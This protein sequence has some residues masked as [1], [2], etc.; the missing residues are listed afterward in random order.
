VIELQLDYLPE[1]MA[2]LLHSYVLNSPAEWWV[3][4]HMVNGTTSFHSTGTI[5]ERDQDW[6]TELTKSLRK[7][8]MTFSFTRSIVHQ[9]SC[10]CAGC[11][12]REYVKTELKSFLEEKMGYELELEEAFFSVYEKE[13]F[14]ST[15]TDAGKGDVAF[16][17][18]LTKDWNACY[19]GLFHSEGRYIVPEFNSLMYMTLENGGCSHFVSEVTHRAPHSRIAYSGWFKKSK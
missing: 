18:N 2:E 12:F 15:H 16:V 13:D 10:Q 19:G 17:I 9:E 6:E 5:K 3:K 1:P 4:T 8:K 14:L 11:H 7:N